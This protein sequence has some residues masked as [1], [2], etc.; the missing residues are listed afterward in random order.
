M[1]DIK[2]DAV[3]PAHELKD[4]IRLWNIV[5]CMIDNNRDKNTLSSVRALVQAQ[6]AM[7]E[8][9]KKL[10]AAGYGPP[11]KPPPKTMFG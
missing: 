4:L 9:V 5:S 10:T 1:S 11:E 2:E 8:K 7:K 6:G 3:N